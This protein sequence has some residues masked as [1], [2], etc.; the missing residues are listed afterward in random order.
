MP[1]SPL[2]VV[3]A[4]QRLI[5][6]TKRPLGMMLALSIAAALL[7]TVLAVPAMAVT[8]V[9]AS[10]TATA[11]DTLPDSIRPG[12]LAQKSEIYATNSDGTN[13]LLATVF[14]QNRQEV[15]WDQVSQ[16]VK[17]AVVSTED[18]RFYEHSGVDVAS[19]LRAAVG[20][21]ASGG[22][23]S[24]ASTVTMQYVRNILVQQAEMMDTKAEREAAYEAA[25]TESLDRK[26]S[27]MR[28]AIALEKQYSK[29]DILLG[30]LN[31]ANFGGSVYGIEAAAQ[32]YF[33]V[34][35]A[36][37]T[38]PQ[39]ATLAATVNEP[40]GLRI[41]DPENIEANKARR[42]ED[43]LASML[44]Q[45]AITQQQYDEA[46]A[47]PVTPNITQP[48]TGCQAAADGAAYFCDYVTWIVKND[49]TFG[50]TAD[51]RWQHFKQ[52]GYEIYTTL[53]T[54]L[55]ANAHETMTEY[56]PSTYDG[57]DL[58]S[59]IVTVEPGTGRILAMAQNTTFDDDPDT[60]VPGATAVN[61][62]TDIDYGGSSGFQVGSTYKVFALAE[63]LKQGHT[64]SDRL[65]GNET[66]WDMATIPNSCQPVSGSWEPANDGS[67][68]PGT[69]SV[70][71][72]L[73]NSVNNAFVAMSQQ[74]DLCN[75]KTT[76]EELGVHRADGD[77]LD[78]QPSSVLGTNEIAP[79]T[80]AAAYAGIAANGM[81]CNPVAIDRIV[82][83]SGQEIATPNA[84]CHQ[85][86]D[87]KI[88][89]TV[90]YAMLG[91]IESGTATA[92]NPYD[93]I[94]HIG[95]TGT[96]DN[97][98]DTWMVGA[99]TA[100]A[101]AVWVGNVSGN[102]SMTEVYPNDYTGSSVRH[103]MWRAVMT[104][105]D[106]LRGGGEFA[107]PDEELVDG[108]S[109]RYDSSDDT[110]TP[111]PI[112]STTATPAP[113]PAPAPV[114]PAPAPTTAPDPV[115]P[116]PADPEPVDPE[117]AAPAPTPTPAAGAGG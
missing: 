10:R 99:S 90:A 96:T 6:G 88:A 82:D 34:S 50:D 68:R 86:W 24:G 18:P 23:S 19:T 27:E 35:A 31:I 1:E 16:F 38:L 44:K 117:P 94:T 15:G 74:L 14:D 111:D 41:D 21:V 43:V 73:T 25:T 87:P 98:K 61:Y 81:Y 33:G 69:M 103:R 49:P 48:T 46:V 85:A 53:D 26:M 17:D 70:Q 12:E 102:V 114:N 47:T 51:E 2:R 60:Q 97:E 76:A 37:L 3:S 66:T 39:A 100:A 108:S 84:D 80:M 106:E 95:K 104:A 112:P 93:G 62:N 71:S 4:F 58:G 65:S 11:L 75:I 54:Q 32:Y 72:A 115:E 92:S 105:N 63:W 9:Y 78:S 109:S 113:V 5:D 59:T 110:D 55:Q 67:S 116:A 107:E 29:D 36:D 79:V 101:T 7:V 56:I 64:L 91:P 42:D 83:P 22:V 57:A 20:N 89:S 40:N 77:P 13:T 30:Y 8:G 28:L 45:K 52:G